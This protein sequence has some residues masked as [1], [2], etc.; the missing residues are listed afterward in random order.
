MFHK[1]ALHCL[2][3]TSFIINP[4]PTLFSAI[5]VCILH[6]CY[7]TYIINIHIYIPDRRYY[8]YILPVAFSSCNHPRPG[9]NDLS[10][11][12][13]HE[14]VLGTQAYLGFYRAEPCPDM[15]FG[16]DSNPLG[17]FLKLYVHVPASVWPS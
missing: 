2:Q 4:A 6:H 14:I 9:E 15:Y 3:D 5:H 11:L 16:A 10:H 1:F 8:V 13:L 17:A 12:Y 7:K